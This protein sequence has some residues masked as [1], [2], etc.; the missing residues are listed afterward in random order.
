MAGDYYIVLGVDRDATLDQIK[1]AYRTQ[2]KRHHPDCCGGESEVF[3][4]VQEAYEVLR[5]PDR[6]RAHDNDLALESGAGTRWT[7]LSR[8]RGASGRSPVEP[9]VPGDRTARW[10]PTDIDLSFDSLLEE[11]FGREWLNASF[12]GRSSARSSRDLRVEVSLTWEQ[13]QHGGRV[14]TSIPL[15]I[16]CPACRG[17][18]W[19]GSFR[20]PRCGGAGAVGREH[21]FVF[22]FPPG[23]ADGSSGTVSLRELGLPDEHLIVH[24]T[25]W[26]W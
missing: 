20:C 21:P 22:E 13:A 17:Y 10:G 11:I 12:P 19:S 4:A 18:G 16:R 24:F 26:D 2:A 8:N 7:H 1:S 25:V 9:L 15:S 23:V 14:R 3:R 6:R 5:D